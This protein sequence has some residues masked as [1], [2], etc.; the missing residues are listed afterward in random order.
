MLLQKTMILLLSLSWNL[1]ST[2][3]SLDSKARIYRNMS[4]AQLAAEARHCIV[5]YKGLVG[6]LTFYRMQ[7]LS[8][9]RNC[10]EQW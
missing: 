3:Q 4:F 1:H 2:M 9:T 7:L 6:S 8:L 5:V 10:L